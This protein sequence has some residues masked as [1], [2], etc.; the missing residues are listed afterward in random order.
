MIMGCAGVSQHASQPARDSNGE[1]R[2][3]H[4]RQVIVTLAPASPERWAD[5]TNAIAR[6]YNLPQV[7]AFP[8][9]SLGVQC[10]VFQIPDGQAVETVMARLAD[11]PRVESVQSNQVFHGLGV[12]H[13]D[14]YAALQYGTRATRADVAHRWATGKG[15]TVAVVDT[16]VDTEHPDPDGGI[17]KAANFV[18]GGEQTF[19]LDSHGTAVTGVIAARANNDVGIVGIAPEADIVVAKA[20]W[21]RTAS[22]LEAV[23]SS[24]TLAKAVDF[25][26]LTGVQVLN[27]SLAGPPD[28]LLAR[29]IGKAVDG[30]ITVVAALWRRGSRPQAFR[31]RW[32]R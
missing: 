20:C 15:V 14:P 13:S 10:V 11:D 7:G 17:I 1:P 28:A 21:Q 8:L 6:T 16:G 5:L 27:L 9:T 24:W 4:A 22:A 29:L 26:I 30:G 23:C 3:L 12:A 19:V 31:R 2:Q 18:E 25:T 32:R